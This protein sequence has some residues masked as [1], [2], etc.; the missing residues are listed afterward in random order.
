MPSQEHEVLAEL[1][2]ERPDL[3]LPLLAAVGVRLSPGVEARAVD[4]TFAALVFDDRA[5]ATVLL[6]ANGRLELVVVVEI[7]LARDEGKRIAWPIYEVLARSRHGT[8]ACVLV[9]APNPRVA[10]WAAEPIELGPSGSRFVA[11]VL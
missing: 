1:F 10:A 7:Q 2:R 6:E 9:V 8:H 3:V 5:D 4:A 11:A